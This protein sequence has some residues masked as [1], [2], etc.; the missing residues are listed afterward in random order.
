MATSQHPDAT[1]HLRS[2]LKTLFRWLKDVFAHSACAA[3]D[4]AIAL[5]ISSGYAGLTLP[6][7]RPVAGQ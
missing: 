4:F 1:T 7:N 5:S 3:A 6:S 2:D